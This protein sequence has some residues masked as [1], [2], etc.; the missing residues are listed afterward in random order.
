MTQLIDATDGGG[1]PG[2]TTGGALG[3][4]ELNPAPSP[5]SRLLALAACGGIPVYPGPATAARPRARSRPGRAAIAVP[6]QG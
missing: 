4:A 1:R 6:A 3:E 2:L 5:L